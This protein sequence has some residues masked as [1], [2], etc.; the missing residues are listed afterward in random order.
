MRSLRHSLFVLLGITCGACG[1][2]PQPAGRSPLV[3]FIGADGATP[4][5]IDELRSEGSLPAFE[6]LIRTGA[7]GKMQS[8]AARRLLSEDDR[9]RYA[10]PIVWTTIATGNVP[11]KHGIRDFVLPIRGS[12]SVW[13]GSEEDPARAELTLPEVS[14][15]GPFT[16][17]LRIH[18]YRPNGEQTVRL[19]L[20]GKE[21]PSISVPVRWSEISV[22][23]PADVLRPVQN[24]L[25]LTFS[26][27][28]PK[29]MAIES[30][31]PSSH[32]ILCR[33]LL[34]LLFIFPNIRVTF[35]CKSGN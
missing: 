24:N 18:S 29:F 11:E 19:A 5:V 7:Y 4:E 30:V 34:L 22:L 21:L 31:I 28:L 32:L 16:L 2:A 12:A 13:M 14:G 33:P 25:S 3:V 23:I 8:L 35:T 15:Q 9:R 1:A 20:N 26:R 27:S 10:S 17:R 6:R